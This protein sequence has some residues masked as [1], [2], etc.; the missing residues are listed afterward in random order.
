MTANLLPKDCHSWDDVQD[1]LFG[2]KG[3]PQRDQLEKESE[4]FRISERLKLARK[5]AGLTQQELAEKVGLKR[6]D[7]S[8]IENGKMNISLDT[9]FDL[10]R[11]V[12]KQISF[13]IM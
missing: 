4:M 12:G 5:D 2:L 6:S 10:F 7:L 11:A 3:T 13:T 1:E 8:L 9:L